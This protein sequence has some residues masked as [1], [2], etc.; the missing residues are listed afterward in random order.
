PLGEDKG[1]IF[2]C[3]PTLSQPDL[4]GG[5]GARAHFLSDGLPTVALCWKDDLDEK[6]QEKFRAKH[7]FL[8][9]LLE[10]AAEAAPYLS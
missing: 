8:C 4:V 2:A 7:A 3:C 1:Q 5:E 10:Q 6:E 9:G